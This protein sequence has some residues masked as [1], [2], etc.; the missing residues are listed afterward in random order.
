MRGENL[1]VGM[2]NIDNELID[3]AES[4]KKKKKTNY[5]AILS[6]AASF[7]LIFSIVFFFAIQDRD[8]M[9]ELNEDGK[10]NIFS[11][12]GALQ[13][14]TSEKAFCGGEANIYPPNDFVNAFRNNDC[15]IVYGTAKNINTVSITDEDR[16]WYITTF[17]IDIID[18]VKKVQD[19]STIKVASI[20]CYEKGSPY[21]IGSLSSELKIDKNTTGLFFL[22]NAPSEKYEINGEKHSADKFANY[23]AMSQYDCD[24]KS[25]DYY[26]TKIEVDK[27][28]VP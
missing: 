15:T 11:L 13:I 18:A 21:F 26:G 28:R 6:I 4:Y 8:K 20:S 16:V 7:F 19:S 2:T 1:L 9:Y 25:F 10:I 14:Q 17:E 5:K 24:G 22:K 12:P 23:Y 27:L 3:F